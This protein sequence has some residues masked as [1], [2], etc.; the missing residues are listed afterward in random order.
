MKS[1][2]KFRLQGCKLAWL[3][4]LIAI[5]FLSFSQGKEYN[6]WYFP[7]FCGIDFTNG[8]PPVSI[9]DGALDD[10]DGEGC[11]TICD[12]LG[13]LLFYTT[14]VVVWN[15][16]HV[17][18]ANGEDMGHW[19]STGA[20]IIP[21][22]VSAGLYYVFNEGYNQNAPSNADFRYSVIDMKLDN[23]YGAVVDSLKSVILADNVYE[24]FCA[25]KHANGND[26]WVV[27]HGGFN[28]LFYSFLVTSDGISSPIVSV[29]GSSS[30]GYG[31]YMKISPDG[32][33]IVQTYSSAPL[34]EYMFFELMDFNDETGVVSDMNLVHKDGSS[35]GVEFS[36]DNTKLYIN[37][38]ANL[39]QYDLQAGTP[40]Q[41]LNS[42]Y[43]IDENNRAFPGALQ[44]GTD[45]KIYCIMNYLKIGTFYAQN[46]LSVIN[47]PNKIGF[48]CE[49]DSLG[50]M[51]DEH[52][53]GFNTGQALPTFVSSFFA[54][55]VFNW[56]NTCFND[57][58]LFTIE[59]I[60]GI[61]SVLWD[62]G[63][64]FAYPNNSSTL[65][66]PSHLFSRA[67][68]FNVVLNVFYGAI[69]RTV[70]QQVIIKPSPQPTI[71]ND[72]LMCDILFSIE[73]DATCDATSYFWNTWET[74]P[75]ITVSDTGTYFVRATNAG[76]CVGKDTIHIG[77]SP[78]PQVDESNLDIQ[79][80]GCG[81]ADGKIIG[82][83]VTG[84]PPLQFY[85]TNSV[86]D[87]VGSTI[88]ISGLSSD[89]YTLLVSDGN[90]CNHIIN[91]YTVPDNGSLVIDSV[92]FTHDHCNSSM[93]EINIYTSSLN[94][95][96]YSIYGDS[97]WVQNGGEFTGLSVGS[98][99]IMI[100]DE[101]NCMGIY[102]NNPIIIQNIA[103]PQVTSV[104]IIPE[105][106][107]LGNGSINIHAIGGSGDLTYS[108]D[109]GSPV[110]Q[111]NDG[112]F[113]DLSAGNYLCS[114]TD[115][116]GCD[117]TFTVYVPL[118]ITQTLEA[119]AGFGSSCVEDAVLVP[120]ELVNFTGVKSFV[121]TLHYKP[122]IVMCDG[123]VELNPQL[124]LGDFQATVQ[125]AIGEIK[126]NW[127][128]QV[129]VTL[130]NQAQMLRLKYDGLGE[131]ISPINWEAAPGESHFY[132]ENLQEISAAYT[133]GEIQVFSQPEIQMQSTESVCVG[134]AL[135][136]EPIITGGNGE[137]NYIWSGPNGFSS[138]DTLLNF[139]PVTTSQAGSYTLSIEDA[140]KCKKSTAVELIV[141]E[142]PTI[143]FSGYDTLFV[144]P[145]YLLDAGHD[146]QHYLWNTGATTEQIA[147]DT[148]GL[149][150]VEA[151][152]GQGCKNS[153]AVYILWAGKSFYIPNAFTPN[154]D[155]LNDVFG[156]IPRIDYVNQYR[157]SIFNRWG[158]LLFESSDLHLGWDG[159][160]QGEACP[161]GA[162]VYR[163]VYN[164][165]GMGPQET[166]VM[167][168][169][170]VLVR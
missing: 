73:L 71:G 50:V 140:M 62:F 53:L 2:K 144:E 1:S 25:V 101:Y 145:G 39:A 123:Y 97:A 154:G 137:K 60:T 112:L 78:Q 85:W 74:T 3:I 141:M 51:L 92:L 70:A 138:G 119:I 69:P 49:Y 41:I 58:T 72:T 152:S 17:H 131:G 155:G 22:D 114:V 117:T 63:D 135:T 113:N 28:S 35:S 23:G 13:N 110:V 126:L 8:S 134:D 146:A 136:I 30:N 87:T 24:L 19:S 79:S 4:L 52:I 95:I 124:E 99:T 37:Q 80:T 170:V 10:N 88:N 48:A 59:N 46:Y 148:T 33:K 100:Q 91:S 14:G 160:Y 120:L 18:M 56:E 132:D 142:S 150:S 161:A 83:Q 93:A 6:I 107:N 55:P 103:G 133:T 125:Q 158:Q 68:T 61:D 164:D 104:D 129:P 130:A 159:T 76:G 45:G 16:N 26:Y 116:F 15:R 54:D 27:A 115:A 108:I 20:V 165:F 156:A 96:S 94:Q 81:M 89:I 149:Y 121:V 111:L 153:D 163:I 12:S 151:T 65:L 106:N 122:N 5:P 86:G 64:F 66:S 167:E 34:S 67:D 21:K 40:E 147:I 9:T 90:G 157:I 98:Y 168:G 32:R 29:A 47:K 109:N 38:P 75:Q 127:Q 42:E 169:T 84:P 162:Y 11:S 31:G 166:K 128:G 36:P 57:S 82:L 105:D 143:A 102:N 139:D 118:V 44:L 77:L 43:R 7:E